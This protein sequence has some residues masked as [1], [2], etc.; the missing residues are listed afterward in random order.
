M[1]N[2]NGSVRFRIN[3]NLTAASR[4]GSINVLQHSI[5]LRQNA[6][7]GGN[8]LSFV[9]DASDYVGQ[10]WTLLQ[11]APTSTLTPAVDAARQHVSFNVTGFDGV[12]VLNWTLDFAA[13][14][15]HQLVPGTYVGAA[16]YPFQPPTVPGL[17]FA[18]DGRTCGQLSG[19]FT[20]SDAVFDTSVQR[21]K[22]TFE[23]HCDGAG[24]ALRGTISYVAPRTVGGV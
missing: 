12:R 11:E 22:A 15:G 5:T 4:S 13:V 8:F 2:G 17:S 6:P 1:G 7:V 3:G 16:R 21:F 24:P 10:G 9:S 19:Q 18:G 20:I 23:Q 14:Q